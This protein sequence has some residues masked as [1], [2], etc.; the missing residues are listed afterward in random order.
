MLTLK[1]T[2]LYAVLGIALAVMLIGLTD[3]ARVALERAADV[4]RSRSYVSDAMRTELS[5]ALALVI[6]ATPV[7]L[8]HLGLVRRT[9]HGPATAVADERACASRA[10]YFFIVLI[11][12][13]VITGTR[14]V[15]LFE[16]LIGTAAFGQRAWEVGAAAAGSIVVGSAWLGHAW[17]RRHDLRVAPRHTAGDWLTR[18]YL[19][20]AL[21]VTALLACVGAGNLLTVVARAMLD[22]RPM[23]ESASWWQEELA[24]ALA[25]TLVAG[26][27][28]VGHWVVSLRLLRA[29]PP[30][31]EAQRT[32]RTRSGYFQV[33]VLA[34]AAI[35]LFLIAQGLSSLFAELAGTWRPTDGSRLIEDIGGP[36]LLAVPFVPLWW[37]H[38]RRANAEALAFGGRERARGARRAGR[39]VIALVGLAGLAIGLTWELQALL[40]AFAS[41]GQRALYSSPD[42]VDVSTSALAG[43]LVGLVMWGPAWVR[44]QRDRARDVEGAALATARRAYLFLVAGLAVVALMIAL[45]FVIYQASRLLLGTELVDDASWAPAVLVVSTVVLL[46]HLWCLRADILVARAVEAAAGTDTTAQRAVETIQISAPQGA[47]F[48]ILNAAIRTELPEGFEL[49]IVSQGP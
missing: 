25:L 18:G 3:I 41:A 31:G 10:T 8:V 33:V 7:F 43:A 34:A 5:W 23:W 48:T 13:G 44:S 30:M 47:D 11:A 37:W 39:L 16:T 9:L 17:A 45:A 6:V 22:L 20:G 2:Y 19:Y 40:D 1:R 24:W 38:Q 15:D 4:F 46:Y 14:L 27:A 35:S 32:S 42:V 28:W 29:A 36:L 12:T 21:F 49:R 26:A